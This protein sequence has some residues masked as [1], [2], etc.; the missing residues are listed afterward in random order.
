M[1]SRIEPGKFDPST[2]H[3]RC[4]EIFQK[5]LWIPFFET[6][7]GYNE[8]VSLEFSYSFDGERVTLGNFTFRLYEDILAQIIGLP[9]QVERFIKTKQ[10]EEKA[11]IPFLC[12]SR[13]GSVN[14]RKEYQG[15]D[16]FILGM[17]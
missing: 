12:R 1:V 11:W 2:I 15:F 13:A 17:K 16:L 7:D 5:K 4:L 14:G 3:E 6:F 10:F 8:K 9:Q